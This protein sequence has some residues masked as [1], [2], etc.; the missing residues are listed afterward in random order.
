MAIFHH[1]LVRQSSFPRNACESKENA[2]KRKARPLYSLFYM[3][4][5]NGFY[6]PAYMYHTSFDIKNRAYAGLCS[7]SDFN[8]ASLCSFVGHGG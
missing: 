7:A 3:L 8:S 6:S 1:P 2:F 5:F 4:T